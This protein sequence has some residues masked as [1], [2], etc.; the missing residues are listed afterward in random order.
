MLLEKTNIKGR[1]NSVNTDTSAGARLIAGHIQKL[2][3][4]NIVIVSERLS[5]KPNGYF[6]GEMEDALAQVPNINKPVTI[7]LEK[8]ASDD[9]V[10]FMQFETFLRPPFR[11]D[12]VITMH[13]NLVYPVMRLFR[14]RKLR[15]PQ[16]IAL[17]SAEEG[18]GFDLLYSP[19]TCL[20]KPLPG[21]AIK[22]ANMVWSEIKNSG[23][24]KF[25]RQVN[26]FPDLVIRN[27][28][29]TL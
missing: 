4:K 21:M 16:D 8:S 1:L 6:T 19:V 17:I 26:V 15:V 29:G 25:K 2:G 27:S 20:R 23:K 14:K 12:A 28:C 9:E 7:E 3:Y 11:A 22:V 10:N 24:G 5:G 18:V 13:S